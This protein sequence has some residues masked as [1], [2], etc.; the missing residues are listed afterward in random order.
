MRHLS[1][2]KIG[3][4]ALFSMLRKARNLNIPVDL[5]LEL[6]DSLVT[7]ILLYGSEIYAP[8]PYKDIENV[9]L[10][11]YQIYGKCNMK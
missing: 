10:K 1:V 2:N 6:F 4:N 9:Q 11:L 3:N 7:P 8:Y 5:I